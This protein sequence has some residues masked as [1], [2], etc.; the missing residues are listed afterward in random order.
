MSGGGAPQSLRSSVVW[1]SETKRDIV[2]A[3]EPAVDRRPDACIGLRTCDDEVP[4]VLGREDLLEVRVLEGVAMG[5][6]D[7]RLALCRRERV[8]DLPLRRI[9]WQFP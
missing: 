4:D 2:A 9:R 6:L 8:D 7:D 5:L 1:A 3:G